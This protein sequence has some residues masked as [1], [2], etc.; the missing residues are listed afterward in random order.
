MS[1]SKRPASPT[2]FSS[3]DFSSSD[4]SSDDQMSYSPQSPFST[5]PR[6]LYRHKHRL[7]PEEATTTT[8][9][10]PFNIYKAILRHPNLFHQFTLRLPLPSLTNLYAIDKEFHWIMNKYM[11]SLIWENARYHA[12]VAAHVFAWSLFPG[13]CISDPLLRPMDNRSHLARDIPSLRWSKMVLHRQTVVHEILTLLA[14]EGHRV[15]RAAQ[16]VLMKFWLVMEQRHQV[17]RE[18][19]LSSRTIWSDADILIFFLF[20]V[21]LELRFAHPV[22]GQG[23]CELSRLLLTQTGLTVLRDVL[24][25]RKIVDYDDLMELII[26]THPPEDLDLDTWPWL[27]DESSTAVLPNEMGLL[28]HEGWHEDGVSMPSALELLELEALRRGIHVGKYLVEFITYGVVDEESARNLP[29]PRCWRGDR[30]VVV[31]ERGALERTEIEGLQRLMTRRMTRRMMAQEEE[32]L[33]RSKTE[34]T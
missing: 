15:P 23:I 33:K 24:K 12:P 8:I 22:Q 19:Y 7:R 16:T 9:Q 27:T 28:L 25:G 34:E 13:L 4:S 20:L 11:S 26:R 5:S 18:A 21:K 14:I 10:R 30:E 6:I 1:S 31:L 3:S 2:D 17:V 32:V 29:M